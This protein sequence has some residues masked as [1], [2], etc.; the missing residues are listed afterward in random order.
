QRFDTYEIKARVPIWQTADLRTYGL[1]G[2][3]IAWIWDRFSWRT[4]DA[5]ELG[6]ASAAT[7]AI[8]SNMMSNRMDGVHCGWGHDYFLGSTPTGGFGCTC[9]FEGSLYLDLAKTS[10]SYELADRSISSGRN[11][12]WSRLVPGAEGRI[13]LWWYPWEGIQMQVGYDVMTFFNTISS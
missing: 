2:P 11:R 7:T 9:E 5:D 6:Q 13:G 3:R 12:R 8:Y 1:F 4:V 10:A